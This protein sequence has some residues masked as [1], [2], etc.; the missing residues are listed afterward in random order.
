[1]IVENPRKSYSPYERSRLIRIMEIPLAAALLYLIVFSDLS[2][3]VNDW[4]E[5]VGV[6]DG[7]FLASF[8]L[9]G[10]GFFVIPYTWKILVHPIGRCLNCGKSPLHVS[11]GI[12]EWVYLRSPWQSALT[13]DRFWPE[14][15]CSDC[16]SN[17]R[18]SAQLH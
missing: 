7:F 9:F 3:W 16:R 12:S 6:A 11:P 18:I 2:W 1:M 14:E 10:F 4:L 13:R 15:E 17:L 5:S 8:L